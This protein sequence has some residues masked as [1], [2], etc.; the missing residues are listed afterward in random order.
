M[1]KKLLVISM[2]TA[3]LVAVPTS[4]RADDKDNEVKIEAKDTAHDKLTE[5]NRKTHDRI[6]QGH[7]GT[8]TAKDANSITVDG[9]RFALTADTKVNKQEEALMPK[10]TKVGQHVCFTT[11]KA[12]D[13]SMQ[14]SQLI[15]VPK[16]T[17][18]VRVREKDD[19]SDNKVEVE[20][21]NK[22]IEV[23]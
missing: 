20:T 5:A 23:K 7:H 6:C 19:D 16:D 10:T 1:K 15:A 12:A 13:G 17:D 9:K 21:P 3:A 4:V 8:V 2:L 22:K 18:K 11:Q 14:I